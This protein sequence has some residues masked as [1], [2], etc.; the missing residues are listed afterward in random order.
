MI[1]MLFEYTLSVI[2]YSYLLFFYL[3]LINKKWEW[4]KAVPAILGIAVIQ[5]VKDSYLDFGS[6]SLLV[7]CVIVTIFLFLNSKTLK[8]YEFLYALMLYSIFCASIIFFVSCAIELNYDVASTWVFGFERYV[9]TFMVKC[10]T[11]I[12]FTLIYKPVM[13]FHDVMENNTENIMVF[14]MSFI[15]IVYSYVFGQSQNNSSIFMY[16]V[17]ISI[18]MMGVLYLFYRYCL[19][20]KQHSDEMI[21]QHTM[22]ITSDYVKRLEDEHNQVRKIRHDIRNQLSALTFLI[23]QQ[24]YE[25]AKG[26]LERLSNDLETKRVSLSGNVYVDAVL[27]QKMNEYKDIKFNIDIQLSDDV[28]IDG[29]DIISLLSNIIDNS[30]EELKRI[31]HNEFTLVVKGNS[32][33][34]RIYEE[35]LCRRNNDLQTDKNSTQHGFGLKIIKEIVRKYG[36]NIDIVIEKDV[37]RIAILLLL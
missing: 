13:K 32:S 12:L 11:I 25:K 14:I 7:D 36:G 22:N 35:N 1:E 17:L 16:T 4:K 37:F 28:Q 19:L 26:I 15:L 20:M 27:R 18:V 34:I 8:L 21:I 30:C 5:F 2:D 29:N 9:F 10:F 33:Q 23:E 3:R 31:H 6:I 24:K